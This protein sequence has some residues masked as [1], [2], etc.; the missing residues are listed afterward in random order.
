VPP[1]AD[2]PI[3]SATLLNTAASTPDAA[4]PAADSMPRTGANSATSVDSAT[5]RVVAPVPADARILV[6]GRAVRTRTFR[7]A[8]GVYTIVI[9]AK[10]FDEFTQRLT[11]VAG[12][13]VRVAPK[14][15]ASAAPSSNAASAAAPVAEAKP[16][17]TCLSAAKQED[18]ASAFELCTADVANGDV[19]AAAT[20]ARM[21]MNGQGTARNMQQAYALYTKAAEGGNR[22][23]QAALG[24][25]LRAGKDVKR[26]EA[27]SARWFKAA[28]DAGDVNAQLEYA[29]ALERGEGV[30]KDQREAREYFRKSAEGGNGIAARRLG[31]LYER[32][33]GG[34]KN[35]ELAAVAY[36]RGAFLGDAESTLTIAKWYR[37]G[38]GV[39]KSPEKALQWFRKAADLGNA[40]AKGEVRRLEK[41]GV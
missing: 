21:H 36:E 5:I 24:Y 12:R 31:R 6:N 9:A 23:A 22:E 3:D 39:T 27:Q 18:W 40:E 17:V 10:G 16:R 41:G 11:V 29:F 15:V 30:R 35:D 37:D 26:D 20:L 1:P 38:R 25:A 7:L 28:A 14:L 2:I 33:E 8:P 13:D 4:L 19:A 34:P 32:G